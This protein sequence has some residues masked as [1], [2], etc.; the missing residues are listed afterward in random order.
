MYLYVYKIYILC[1][2]FPVY[3]FYAWKFNSSYL[4]GKRNYVYISHWIVW[5]CFRSLNDVVTDIV[6]CFRRREWSEG[7]NATECALDH[8]RYAFQLN[9]RPIERH[10]R[11]SFLISP[12]FI[13]YRRFGCHHTLSERECICLQHSGNVWIDSL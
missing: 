7:H 3:F 11:R 8:W 4:D 2:L 13:L 6:F 12:S 5:Y 10:D 1:I 9:Y